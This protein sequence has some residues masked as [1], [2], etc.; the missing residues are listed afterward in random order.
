VHDV[1]RLELPV[2][3]PEPR[4]DPEG[5]DPDDLLLLDPIDPDTSIM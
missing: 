4:V 5:L 1:D 3:V 2:V